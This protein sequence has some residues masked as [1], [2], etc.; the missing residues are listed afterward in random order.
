[1]TIH[2]LFPTPVMTF[3][4]DRFFTEEENTFLLN[5]ET[6]KNLGN[7]TSLN[8][9]ILDESKSK[10]LKVFIEG[11][12]EEYFKKVIKPKNKVIP[13]ITQSWLNYTKEGE[14]HHK[15][16]HPNS[17]LSGILYVK[18]DRKKDKVYFSNDKY[19]QLDIE[20]DTFD[21]WNSDSWWFNVGTGD[22]F[23]FPSSLMHNVDVVEGSIRVSLSFNTF[24]K[25]DLG[26]EE[27]LT[28]LKL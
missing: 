24:L 27:T 19:K 23:I 2:G 14:F 26:L 22:L 18:A 25:G 21:I 12:L 5:Q 13:Y 7:T 16:K 9:N 3:N 4:L 1:M 15:H 17:F 6:Y 28:E 8:R 20:V 10:N 11:C